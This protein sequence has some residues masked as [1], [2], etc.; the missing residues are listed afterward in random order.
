MLYTVHWTLYTVHRILYTLHS[1][2]YTLHSTLYT[3]HSTLCT[4]HCTLYTVHCILLTVNCIMYTVHCTQ[5]TLLCIMFTIHC[6]PYTAGALGK[7]S[8]CPQSIPNV[9][10]TTFPD[11]GSRMQGTG[12]IDAQTSWATVWIVSN[13]SLLWKQIPTFKTK[14]ILLHFTALCCIIVYFTIVQCSALNPKVESPIL[15]S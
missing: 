3:L 4:V 7:Y 1:T 10:S 6:T 15:D 8:L 14:C 2:L 5:Y 13:E 9:S 11:T 12:Y